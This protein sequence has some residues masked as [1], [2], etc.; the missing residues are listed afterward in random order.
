MAKKNRRETAKP[1]VATVGQET[2]AA[3]AATIGW[4]LS[5]I[6]A[7]ICEFGLFAARLYFAANPQAQNVA[8]LGGLLIFAAVVV[9]TFTLILTPVVYKVRQVA[10]PM[11]VTVGVIAIGLVPWVVILA[12]SLK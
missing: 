10:P 12:Q 2:S 8:Q 1:L 5:A 6:T 3:D 9:G 11:P 4:L 7:V